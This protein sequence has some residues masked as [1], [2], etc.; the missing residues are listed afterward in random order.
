MSYDEPEADSASTQ[1]PNS[2]GAKPL[3]VAVYGNDLN[4]GYVL[5]KALRSQG[6]DACLFNI[7]YKRGQDKHHWWSTT[8]PEPE[9]IKDFISVDITLTG[10]LI[11]QPAT[12][13]IYKEARKY[14]VLLI[15]EDGP[16]VFSEL[17][18]P[19]K[20]FLSYGYDLQNLPFMLHEQF[21]FRAM[22]RAT[23]LALGE[24][25][26]AITKLD[27]H[28]PGRIVLR[29]RRTGWR[30]GKVRR[31][32]ARQ[33]LGLKQCDRL[34]CAPSRLVLIDKLNLDRSRVRHLP[35]QMD[36]SQLLEIDNEDRREAERVCSKFDFVFLHPTRQMFL[37]L[38]GDQY[39]KDNHKLI[40]AYAGFVK[41]QEA[42]VKLMMVRKGREQDIQRMEELILQFGLGDKVDWIDEMPGRKL[43]A[44][45]AQANVVVCDQYNSR[46]GNLGSIG[47]EASFFGRPLISN[48]AD[49]NRL[50]YGDDLPSHVFNAETAECIE[51][52]MRRIVSLSPSALLEMQRGA[53]SWL[54][55]WHCSKASIRRWSDTLHEAAVEASGRF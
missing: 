30:F 16:A 25:L 32:Q 19:T 22:G 47:R 10:K 37:R 43:R 46:L 24:E 14:D 35:M 15:A 4:C 45:F 26:Q 7:D 42:N 38:D 50:Y 29:L 48:F 53:E 36:Y 28:V 6:C 17:Q 1:T 52:A 33:R 34:I 5:A 49:W 12:Q 54:R 39:L 41:N 18:G 2:D 3:R 55:R 23:K 51:Q 21:C 9:L 11:D 8:P 13:V 44:Y 31:L 20:V 40:K 27:I